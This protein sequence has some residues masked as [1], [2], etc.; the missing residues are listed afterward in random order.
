MT[1]L[2]LISSRHHR[3]G[4]QLRFLRSFA[5]CALQASGERSAIWYWHGHDPRCLA[6][7]EMPDGLEVV[8][9]EA[10]AR[11]VFRTDIADVL[12]EG[13]MPDEPAAHRLLH[14]R[15]AGIRPVLFAN[16]FEGIAWTILGQQISVTMAARLKNNIAARYGVPVAGLTEP[17]RL[18]PRADH[19]LAASVQDLRELQLSQA[20]ATTLLS[21]ARHIAQGDWDEDSPLG[22]PTAEAVAHLEGFR[23]IGRWSAEYILLRVVGHPDVIPAG[24]VALQRAWSRLTGMPV[25]EAELRQAGEAWKGWRSDFAFYLW[26]DNVAHRNASGAGP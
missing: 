24:D 12:P 1:A 23:G 10:V 26:L 15:Y 3:Y 9:E 22:Q 8:G 19:L 2:R 4:E 17:V 14:R 18:F 11:R 7:R 6:V 20:K 13:A 25:R 21:L 5:A 16:A